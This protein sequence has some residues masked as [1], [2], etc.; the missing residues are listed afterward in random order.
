MEPWPDNAFLQGYY[1][2]LTAECTAPDLVVEG[3]MP[4]NLRVLFTAMAPTPVP[5]QE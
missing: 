1:E 2:P 5:T 4:K 3:E